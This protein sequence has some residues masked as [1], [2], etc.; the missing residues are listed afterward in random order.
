MGVPSWMTVDCPFCHVKA[1]EYCVTFTKGKDNYKKAT[2]PHK[3]RVI[4]ARNI[5]VQNMPAPPTQQPISQQVPI[6]D[7]TPAVDVSKLVNHI[8]FIIDASGS[9][10]SIIDRARDVFNNQLETIKKNAATSG[11]KTLISMYKFGTT[12]A[13]IMQDYAPENALPLTHYNYDSNMGMTALRDAVWHA[14]AHFSNLPHANDT[15]HSFL[16]VTV[17]DGEENQSKISL[18]ALHTRIQELQITDR[19]TFAFM[20]PRGCSRA[21]QQYT[22]AYPGNIQEWDQTE[23]GIANAGTI[24]SAGL[25]DY[26]QS[27]SIGKK[28]TQSFFANLNNINDADLRNLKDL[29]GEF[30]RWNVANKVRIDEFVKEMIRTDARVAG[31]ISRFQPGRGYYQLTKPELV[32]EYKDFAILDTNTGAIYGGDQAR[33]LAGIPTGQRVRV[34]PG[35]FDKYKLFILSASNNRNLMENTVFLYRHTQS[36]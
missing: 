19:W 3:Q 7:P 14:I 35:D 10:D 30:F 26:Y 23:K 32:Q 8:A 21:V 31:K 29:N 4:A 22:G 27:R 11:Q 18:N 24:I 33:A 36:A 20:T 12:V 34:R 17:T 15:N 25:G 16:I 1:G 28:S 9:M 6:V 5:P 13:T 2:H